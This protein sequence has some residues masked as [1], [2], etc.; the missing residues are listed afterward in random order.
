MEQEARGV[1]VEHLDE[2]H[3]EVRSINNPAEHCSPSPAAYS[4]IPEAEF[5]SS[6]HHGGQKSA[7][8]VPGRYKY[9]EIL[10]RWRDRRRRLDAGLVLSLLMYTAR[11]LNYAWMKQPYHSLPVEALRGIGF[12]AFWSSGSMYMHRISPPGMSATMLML[13]NA[14][15]GG[16]GQS[17]GAIMGGKLQS[18]VGT[19]KMLVYSGI[20]DICFMGAPVLYLLTKKE[21]AFR[22]VPI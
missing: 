11:F 8:T 13:L 14:M 6:W 22:S 3:V 5:A 7:I 18:K 4:S 12:A 20:F 15:Y 9:R 19:V 16:L 21:R 10:N 1:I 17:L 2:Q